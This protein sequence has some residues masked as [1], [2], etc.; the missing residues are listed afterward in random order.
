M[1]KEQFLTSLRKSYKL[2]NIGLLSVAPIAAM[3]GQVN[4][5]IALIAVYLLGTVLITK[6]SLNDIR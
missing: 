4:H 1:N 2:T 6:E 3:Q 5:A